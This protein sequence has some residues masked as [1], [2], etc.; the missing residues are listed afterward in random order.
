MLDE[1]VEFYTKLI[2]ILIWIG[3]WVTIAVILLVYLGYR[4]VRP[5]VAAA[6]DERRMPNYKVERTAERLARAELRKI[7]RGRLVWHDTIWVHGPTYRVEFSKPNK[8]VT[9]NTSTNHVTVE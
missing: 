4:F 7:H 3:P 8:K 5:R 1:L 6:I 2:Q 9:V